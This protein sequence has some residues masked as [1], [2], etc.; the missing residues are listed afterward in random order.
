MPNVLSAVS[1]TC[2]NWESF[3]HCWRHALGRRHRSAPS[4]APG[5]RPPDPSPSKPI[6]P[7]E[8]LL[9]SA[10][11]G[12]PPPSPVPA[13]CGRLVR[14]EAGL[15]RGGRARRL[16]QRAELNA[17]CV[18]SVE[19]RA[20][21]PWRTPYRKLPR[22]HRGVVSSL[23]MVSRASTPATSSIPVV[24]ASSSPATIG[25]SNALAG[26]ALIAVSMARRASASRQV[27]DLG[28]QPIAVATCANTCP[29]EPGFCGS[30]DFA[31]V[32]AWYRSSCPD[33]PAPCRR[34]SEW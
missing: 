25:D 31:A 30:S 9:R 26:P 11:P 20:V 23:D 27:A 29:K 13:G 3:Q 22:R 34:R 18:N 5:R 12:S 6:L 33:R 14:I 28:A 21:A 4:P 16:E 2:R 32:L 10:A 24:I 17:L 19:P 8:E 15:D 1:A 7:I